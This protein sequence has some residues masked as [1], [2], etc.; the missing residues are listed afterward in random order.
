MRRF[1]GFVSEPFRMRPICNYHINNGDFPHPSGNS[2]LVTKETWELLVQMCGYVAEE[3][4]DVYFEPDL[5]PPKLN[6]LKF[7][8]S[9]SVRKENEM[10][11]GE[12][13][14]LARYAAKAIGLLD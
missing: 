5:V 14:T 8:D 1:P 3:D 11:E 10:Q 9:R 12:I 6:P 7:T 4:G 2:C 13:S